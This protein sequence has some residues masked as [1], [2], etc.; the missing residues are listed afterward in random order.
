MVEER[1]QAV[2]S[3]VDIITHNTLVGTI[4]I[5]NVF[6]NDGLEKAVV[7]LYEVFRS[8]CDTSLFTLYTHRSPVAGRHDKH[9][10]TAP[11][12]IHT[13]VDNYPD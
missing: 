6:N 7:H 11:W 3:L 1:V 2:V 12:C 9:V 13:Q 5:N 8:L 10:Q 4:I